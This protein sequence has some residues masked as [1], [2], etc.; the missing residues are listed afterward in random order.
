MRNKD[1][2]PCKLIMYSANLASE[3][4]LPFVDQEVKI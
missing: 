2:Q 4:D 1:V 3:L